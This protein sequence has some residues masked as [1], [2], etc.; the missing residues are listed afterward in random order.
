MGG[1]ANPKT[2]LLLAAFSLMIVSSAMSRTIYVDTDAFGAN[3]GSSWE[4]A[5]NFLQDALADANSAVK[6]VEIRVALGIYTPDSNSANPNGSG[7]R[8]ATFQLI[9]GVALK[10]G[11]A[12]FG[13]PDP[14]ARDIELYETI[15]SGD[16]NGNDRDVGNPQD[17]L[18][19][20]CCAENSYHV[21]TSV[22]SD[23]KTVLDGFTIT[24]G[25]AN[26]LLEDYYNACGAGLFV[27][28]SNV[29]VI[30][31][32]FRWNTATIHG[33]GMYNYDSSPTLNNC[34][35]TENRAQAT[36]IGT[37]GGG[38]CNY[39]SSAMLNKCNFSN[40][41]A[42]LGGAM[43]NYE[44]SPIVTG[45]TFSG[46]K[47]GSGG[48]MTNCESNPILNGCTFVGN[49]AHGTGVSTTGGG[50]I[51]NYDSNP[52]LTNCTF[53]NNYGNGGGMEN[54]RSN[55]KLTNCIFTS[56]YVS[57]MVNHESNVILNNCTFSNNNADNPWGT[58]AGGA[59]YNWGSDLTLTNCTFAQNSANN[60]NAL[61][62][63]SYLQQY[64]SNLVLINCILWDGADEI[65]NNDN[66]V[67]LITYSDVQGGWPAVGNIDS[68]PLFVD[69][70]YWD[71]NGTP[72]DANDD[73]W[74]EGDYYLLPDSPCINAGDPNHPYD[75]N[76]TDL[77]G[78]PRVIGG[79]IDMGAYEYSPKISAEVRIV[80]RT[81]NL[82]SKGKWI[83]AFLW[84][85]ESYKF[86]DIDSSSV[87]LEDEIEPQWVLFDEEEQ[88]AMIMFNREEVQDILDV[89]QAELTIT[90]RLTDGT[91]FEAKDV[92]IVIDKG[93]RKSAL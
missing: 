85:P 36:N 81:V 62:C 54:F 77:D 61:A 49:S 21:V 57:G 50:G 51:S 31:C 14:N 16:L 11:Y 52:K 17:L 75:P 67:I 38:M 6:P 64:P 5:Y 89:G 23:E 73:F 53:S 72:E 69:P 71:A 86:I 28:L 40:N 37:S 26:C 32:T 59:M 76:E 79:R 90:G 41:S 46:N 78:K 82:K 80:P 63:D 13:A 68:D 56:N 93:G 45:C 19:D 87:L 91:I 60:G 74:V 22:D 3:D 84:L 43:C 83:N 8:E 92:I 12:G 44:C 65:R 55:P 9:S 20:P 70:A 58:G 47:G 30:N 7:D 27:M 34:R 1:C 42:D 4:D 18:D 48:G 2:Y 10:G 35:F 24:A 25:N 39:Q 66:S 88:V 29:E 33:G 15:L